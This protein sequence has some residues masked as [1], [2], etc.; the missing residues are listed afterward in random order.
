MELKYTSKFADIAKS[1]FFRF[2]KWDKM[3]Q[4]HFFPK[5]KKSSQEILLG[6][7]CINHSICLFELNS[8]V[9]VTWKIIFPPCIYAFLPLDGRVGE[10]N[11]V[12]SHQ[13]T[14]ANHKRGE[15]PVQTF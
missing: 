11:E 9:Y 7:F 8:V 10:S 13:S 6:R 3:L 14:D 15:E 2:G 1:R 12:S 5:K 4:I